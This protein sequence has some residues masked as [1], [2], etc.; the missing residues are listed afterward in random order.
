MTIMRSHYRPMISQRFSAVCILLA[1]ALGMV[2][3]SSILSVS[4]QQVEG[5]QSGTVEQGGDP[6]DTSSETGSDQVVRTVVPELITAE[7]ITNPQDSA[8][9]VA[10]EKQQRK[11]SLPWPRTLADGRNLRPIALF[12]SQMDVLVSKDF[13]PVDLRQFLS[14]LKTQEIDSNNETSAE[15]ISSQYLVEMVGRQLICRQGY[16]TIQ[17]RG[18]SASELALGQQNVVIRTQ[19]GRLGNGESTNSSPYQFDSEGGAFISLE[20]SDDESILLDYLWSSYGR[21][22]G[23]AIE[24]D[25]QLPRVEQSTLMIALPENRQLTSTNCVVERMLE[26]EPKFEMAAENER[27]HWYKVEAGGVTELSLKVVDNREISSPAMI[28][29]RSIL[30]CDI[31]PSGVDWISR[32]VFERGQGAPLPTLAVVGSA[33][34]S[35]KLDGEE[36]TYERTDQGEEFSLL[37]LPVYESERVSRVGDTTT[38]TIEGY[39]R[40]IEA[41]NWYE[42]PSITLLGAIDASINEELQ[43]SF[44]DPMHPIAYEWPRFWEAEAEQLLENGSFTVRAVGP[45]RTIDASSRAGVGRE[46]EEFGNT[47]NSGASQKASPIRIMLSERPSEGLSEINLQFL[48]G[49]SQVDANARIIMEIDPGRVGPI[50]LLVEDEWEL[51]SLRFAET[52]REIPLLGNERTRTSL[53]IWPDP[54]EIVNGKV[55]LIAQGRRV[56]PSTMQSVDM[57]RSWF[58]GTQAK[59]RSTVLVAV[60]PTSDLAWSRKTALASSRLANAPVAKEVLDLFESVNARTLWFAPLDGC[61]PELS[62][63]RPSI[64]FGAKTKLVIGYQ[65]GQMVEELILEMTSQSQSIESL[66]VELFGETAAPQF[67]WWLQPNDGSDSFRLNNVGESKG[68][69]KETYQLD[70]ENYSLDGGCV[71]AR[72][73][74]PVATGTKLCLPII[75]G[76]LNQKAE[77]YLAPVF[78]VVNRSNSI[79]VVPSV[80]LP[81]FDESLP[82]GIKTPDNYSRRWS[83]LKYDPSRQ[84]VI[85]VKVPEKRSELNLVQREELRYRGSISGF[86]QVEVECQIHSSTNISMELT[87]D[88]TLISLKRDNVPIAIDK[89]RTNE[90]SLTPDFKDSLVSAVWER[91]GDA[92]QFMRRSQVPAINHGNAIVMSSQVQLL[93]NPDSFIFDYSFDRLF[94]NKTLG[95]DSLKPGET[96]LLFRREHVL[97][98][99]C[100]LCFSIFCLSLWLGRISIFSLFGLLVLLLTI[101]LFQNVSMGYWAW[102]MIPVVCGGLLARVLSI[103]REVNQPPKQVI[104]P[105]HNSDDD[106]SVPN[107]TVGVLLACSFLCFDTDRA[108]G[109]DAESLMD[110]EAS[111]DVLVPVDAEGGFVGEM[112]YIPRNLFNELFSKDDATQITS[113][114]FLTANY[115]MEIA[116]DGDGPSSR[117]N[118]KKFE[119]QYTL[120][121]NEKTLSR[122]LKLPIPYESVR[123]VELI[124]QSIRILPFEREGN[125]T[126]L[127]T[128]PLER[129]LKIRVTL[130]PNV[131]SD[132]SWERI[133]FPIPMV[134]NSKLLIESATPLGTV[135]IGGANGW[136]VK[137]QKNLSRNWVADIGPV[138]LMQVEMRAEDDQATTPSEA[139]ARRY[140]VRAGRQNAVIDCELDVPVKQA[141]GENFQFVI[142]D[143]KMPKLIGEAWKLIGSEL[144]SP[145]R[146]LVTVQSL[147]DNPG[148]IRL[149]WND[150][151]EGELVDEDSLV[152]IV[153]PEVIASALGENADP[154]IALQSEE[155]LQIEAVDGATSEPLSVDQFLASWGGYRGSIGKAFVPVGKI[156]SLSV[157]MDQAASLNLAADQHYH[158]HLS[159]D[160]IMIRYRLVINSADDGTELIR[161]PVS[162]NLSI[163][164]IINNDKAVALDPIRDND[165]DVYILNVKGENRTSVI[166]MV[167]VMPIDLGQTF[168]FPFVKT[169]PFSSEGKVNY[170]VTRDYAVQLSNESQLVFDTTDKSTK[171]AVFLSWIPKGSRI[172]GFWREGD[173]SESPVPNLFRGSFSVEKPLGRKVFDQLTSISR[174]DR[175]WQMNVVFNF[176]G[177]I[178]DT[179][180]LEIPSAWSDEL[181][182]DGGAVIEKAVSIDADTTLLQ[183]DID[184]VETGTQTLTLTSK[185]ASNGLSAVSVPAV[186]VIDFEIRNLFAAVPAE[187]DNQ[188]TNWQV[189]AVERTELPSYFEGVEDLENCRVYRAS[190]ASF[191][192]ELAP[193]ANQELAASVF[194]TDIHVFPKGSDVLVLQHWEIF[195]GS[196]SSV[197][198]NLP[199]VVKVLG[200][201][202]NG[203]SQSLQVSEVGSNR[204]LELPYVLDGCSQTVQLLTRSKVDDV[205]SYSI[206]PVLAELKGGERW[207]SLYEQDDQGE[208][209]SLQQASGDQ[210]RRFLSLGRSTI[211]S[212]STSLSAGRVDEADLQSWLHQAIQRYVDI[213]LAAGEDPQLL[214]Q[215]LIANS[216]DVGVQGS[217]KANQGASKEAVDNARITWRELNSRVQ[218][219]FRIAHEEKIIFSGAPSQN[220]LFPVEAFRGYRVQ[221]VIEG[222]DQEVNMLLRKGLER[223]S[224]VAIS[225]IPS[226]VFGLFGIIVLWSQRNHQMMMPLLGNPSFWLLMLGVF[227]WVVLPVPIAS[228]TAILAVLIP[229]LASSRHYR[230]LFR[231]FFN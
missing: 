21:L 49:P 88:W 104:P 55:D 83:R 4:G 171:D 107:I 220:A 27:V 158:V 40:G 16:L 208:G 41:E 76:A 172:V 81:E 72:R 61:A 223:Q 75:L 82:S 154:W 85:A 148:P 153:I 136:L 110:T 34:T 24:Y 165:E 29:R 149:I 19:D 26:V 25:L 230:S 195:P 51:Q 229:L 163:T 120:L 132:D 60:T 108:N 15:I 5:N 222:T 106:F 205:S 116:Q 11:L 211:E 22:V 210:S 128:L 66:T 231:L 226:L 119:V 151:L 145:S 10:I 227:C 38:L 122:S 87:D 109:Q 201:W 18:E 221:Q 52:N 98:F 31:N 187:I 159:S 184:A 70:L 166:E 168:Q 36:I 131:V 206:L 217:A 92:R 178:S 130:T 174:V 54:A 196:N 207:I 17:P 102:V 105:K 44:A 214:R 94:L 180:F 117:L 167:G 58:I 69:D 59:G 216:T 144:Y 93:A 28:L 183:I 150:V 42:L 7:D 182:L 135:R 147:K 202:V 134:A 30:Q 198:I 175:R 213:A 170:L 146:R 100:L 200:G 199:E 156:P 143:S 37:T 90:V 121:Q 124:D 86:D 35:V 192:V 191:S 62:L 203:K 101:S 68:V 43:L 129:V 228:T 103:D 177:P 225:P 127:V 84:P 160:R 190:N 6:L 113:S 9:D 218:K 13:L 79:T 188:K 141:A 8:S 32:L 80:E 139:L 181:D 91:R 48:I 33:I 219:D 140:W 123:R 185:A 47:P 71:Y 23:S 46:S 77:I 95:N 162:S 161:I 114:R 215:Q 224:A 194:L 176:D 74:R 189:S 20:R 118:L 157:R 197:R 67:Q 57:P 96:I 2:S 204:T 173:S 142:L 45:L 39:E 155:N 97:A 99:G 3:G 65:D 152:R 78:E 179:L 12:S 186:S 63:V 212:I 193:I 209:Q 164:H 14:A 50:K 64:D 115:R 111:V 56:L 125:F 1:L 138:G 137:E 126:R 133:E 112:V 169:A 89:Q 53:E 73:V